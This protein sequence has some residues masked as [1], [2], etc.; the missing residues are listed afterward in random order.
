MKSL[1]A[2]AVAALLAGCGST[3]VFLEAVSDDGRLAPAARYS[4]Q[5]DGV[6]QASV[7]VEAE[8][9]RYEELGGRETDTLRVRIQVA[10]AGPSAITVPLDGTAA[11]DDVGRRF[12]L[13]GT[14]VPVGQEGRALVVPGGANRSVEALFDLGAPG[15]WNGV[16]SVAVSWSYHFRDGRREHRTRFLPVRYVTRY[17]ERPY[18]VGFGLGFGY[19]HRHHHHHW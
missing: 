10:N 2:L 3:E 17:Y 19:Y 13:V 5:A 7:I 1:F 18:P 16:G 11:Q 4:V 8:G 14:Y 9:L 15:R 12:L 6:E